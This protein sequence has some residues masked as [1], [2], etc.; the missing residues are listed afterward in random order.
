[1]VPTVRLERV[2]VDQCA[3]IQT[4]VAVNVSERRVEQNVEQSSKKTIFNLVPEIVH[5]RDLGRDEA[6]TH[7]NI[8]VQP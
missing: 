1:M 4:V 8:R 3:A 6:A 2:G 7:N 5:P